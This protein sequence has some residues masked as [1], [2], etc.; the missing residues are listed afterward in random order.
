MYSMWVCI[1][2]IPAKIPTF[3]YCHRKM[4]LLFS[5]SF[6]KFNRERTL[7]L[8][9]ASFTVLNARR[10]MI[11]SV[12][13]KYH[14]IVNV[15][16]K[17]L[18]SHRMLKAFDHFQVRISEHTIVFSVTFLKKVSINRTVLYCTYYIKAAWF[19]GVKILS[20][21]VLGGHFTPVAALFS[22]WRL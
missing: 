17:K 16:M 15:L 18:Y 14:G 3:I 10:K 12:K 1:R 6:F 2:L 8:T 5:Y 22:L 7:I 4:N 19:A 9:I 20:K 21:N 13:D 11:L